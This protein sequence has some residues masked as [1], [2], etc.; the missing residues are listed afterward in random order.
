MK[1]TWRKVLKNYCTK[2]KQDGEEEYLY[3]LLY[4]SYHVTD[5]IRSC[6]TLITYYEV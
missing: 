2:M 3:V 6:D 4:K 1:N 5:A